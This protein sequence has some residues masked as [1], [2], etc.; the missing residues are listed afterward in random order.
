[1]TA[2]TLFDDQLRVRASDPDTSRAAAESIKPVLGAE[3]SRVLAAVESRGSMGATAY[4]ALLVLERDGRRRQQSV[5]SRRL[6]DLR[7]AGLLRDSGC[8]RPGMTGRWLIVWSV[9]S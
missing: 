7:D 5:V 4:E 9:V 8:R 2:E 1:M 3:C 6:T